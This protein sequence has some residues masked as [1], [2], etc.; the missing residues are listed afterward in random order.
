MSPRT[1]YLRLHDGALASDSAVEWLSFA[2]DGTRRAGHSPLGELAGVAHGARL[3]VLVPATAVTMAAVTLPPVKRAQQRQAALF[4]LED[5]LIDEPD[6][7]H[8]AL[9]E[10]TAAGKVPLLVVSRARLA[11]WLDSLAG[12]HLRP[13]RVVV[14]VLALP[15]GEGA[16]SLLWEDD[17]VLVRTGPHSGYHIAAAQWPLLWPRLLAEAGE[18]PPQ[19]L[20]L[21]DGR[22]APQEALAG[23]ELL[24]GGGVEYVA[25]SSGL[26]WLVGEQTCASAINLLQGPFSRR[27]QW[28][29]RLRPWR[30]AAALLLLW[31]V[32]QGGM[33]LFDLRALR[34][35]E[36]RLDQ[37]MEALYRTTFPDARKVVDPALQMKQRLVALKSGDSG[38]MRLAALAAPALQGAGAQVKGM[39]YQEGALDV[40]VAIADTAALDGLRAT[41]VGKGL[42]VEISNAASQEGR[43]ESRLT[44]RGG[45][46]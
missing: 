22:S 38:F 26:Q 7:L 6:G 18:L 17:G 33:A 21:F 36:A 37:Q 4:A 35:E 41:L 25:N 32:I 28:G 9:G 43:V 14:D 40:D 31:L 34:G 27:E 20:R 39:R 44:L 29:V 12:H 2:A 45:G 30:P 46:A 16:W 23:D 5:Q 19:R 13:E 8:A 3:V 42:Q 10:R 1:L 11:A 15:L 24:P